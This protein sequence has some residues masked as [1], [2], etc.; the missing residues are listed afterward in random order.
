L[1]GQ[2]G[3][4]LPS[5]VGDGTLLL[6]GNA[7]TTVDSSRRLLSREQG[8]FATEPT[9]PISKRFQRPAPVCRTIAAIATAIM[10][11][12]IVQTIFLFNNTVDEPYHIASAVVMYDV[13]KHASG[14]EQPPLTRIVAGLPLY[15]RGVRLPSSQ[16]TSAVIAMR[17]TYFQ[18][19]QILF[20]SK[21]SYWQVLITARL[22]MLIFPVI[23]LLYLYLLAAWIGNED[24]AVVSVILFSLDPALL[25]HS[26][27]VCTDVAACAGFL[28]ATYHGLRWLVLRGRGRAVATGIAI[29]GAIA[30]KY[31]CMFVIPAIGLLL[32]VHP[33]SV[34]TSNVPNKLRTYFRRWPSIGQMAIV[35]LVAFVTLWGTYFFN[36]DRMSNQ[37]IFPT[38]RA[39][40]QKIPEFVRNARIPM[41]SFVLG[42]MRLI[43]H[44]KVGNISYL[45]GR[46][47]TSGWWYYFPEAIA[48]KE[49]IALLAG[50][51][52]ALFLLFV[53]A[54]RAPW[55][56]AAILIPP[57]VFLAAAMKGNLDIG[58]RH[59]LPVL[60]FIYLLIC[61]QLT[62]AGKRGWAALGTLVLLAVIESI[63]IAPNFTEAFNLAV[64]GPAQGAKYLID[65]NI[66]WGQDV[67]RLADWLHSDE[68]RGRQ[69][70]LRLFMFPDKSLSRTLGLD[71][72]ACFRDTKHGLLAISK[73]VRYGEGA[74]AAED[75][76]GQP[77]PDYDWLSAYPIVKRIGY[78]IDVYDLDV[79]S[80]PGSSPT[81]RP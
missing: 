8:R 24:V 80:S 45:N 9:G 68:A 50:L 4:V 69:Y 36:I 23:A 16:L 76:N 53:P 67:V 38:E 10:L 25:G 70:S 7:F 32:V 40:W 42:V 41:P 27:W 30:A 77:T 57:A 59:V 29:G 73:N 43:S 31:S 34:F 35:A 6:L 72:A 78:S 48:I 74:G 26:T 62:R 15:L 75:W 2:I 33:L 14:V 51:A 12:R 55:R 46:F 3:T 66:D 21:L 61:F 63:T 71:P 47:S 54:T 58:I 39:E 44:N 17:D 81:T 28:A 20:H 13:G 79:P 1:Y 37:T 49:P 60:P 56:V 18:G 64:G 22:S 52:L 11:L 19:T 65:S 5:F